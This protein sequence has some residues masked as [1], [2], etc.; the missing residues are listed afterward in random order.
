MA[1]SSTGPDAACL[2]SSPMHES[3]PF[4]SA[5]PTPAKSSSA[6]PESKESPLRSKKSAGEKRERKAPVYSSPLPPCKICGGK[7]SGL[8]YGVNTCEA[9]KLT[10]P[11]ICSKLRILCTET[12]FLGCHE[13]GFFRRAIKF[14]RKYRC[15]RQQRCDVVGGR[16]VRTSC[17]FCRLQKCLDMG[18][19][20]SAIKTG[21]YTHAKR[22]EN[23]MEVKRLELH[24]AVSGDPNTFLSTSGSCSS[25]GSGA[26][27]NDPSNSCHSGHSCDQDSD[28]CFSSGLTNVAC[29]QDREHQFPGHIPGTSGGSGDP[30]CAEDDSRSNV[31]AN[32]DGT[33][34]CNDVS[35]NITL[36]TYVK[37][38]ENRI[39]CKNS[40]CTD[41][42]YKR[43]NDRSFVA[44][45]EW[46]GK[47]T[48]SLWANPCN[49]AS[50]LVSL[51]DNYAI[52]N[53]REDDEEVKRHH[54][55]VQRKGV[56]Y[57][58]S[59]FPNYHALQEPHNQGCELR[60]PKHQRE[61]QLCHYHTGYGY[62]HQHNM[63]RH[64]N[65]YQSQLQQHVYYHQHDTICHYETQRYHHHHPHHYYHRQNEVVQD[66]DNQQ[67]ICALTQINLPENLSSNA[68]QACSERDSEMT[69]HEPRP[70]CHQSQCYP[71]AMIPTNDY[72]GYGG[73]IKT[74]PWDRDGEASKAVLDRDH[75]H[76]MVDSPEGVCIS[77]PS[78]PLSQLTERAHDSTEV[79]NTA[80]DHVNDGD[81]KLTSEIE[82]GE[83]KIPQNSNLDLNVMPPVIYLDDSYPVRRARE[84]CSLPSSACSV[85]SPSGMT[86]ALPVSPSLTLSPSLAS[87]PSPSML[88]SLMPIQPS[89][90]DSS[91]PNPTQV[92]VPILPTTRSSEAQT[93]SLPTADDLPNYWGRPS[94][95]GITS[96]STCHS[97]DESPMSAPINALKKPPLFYTKPAG[98]LQG[99]DPAAISTSVIEYIDAAYRKHTT[100]LMD[101]DPEFLYQWQLSYWREQTARNETFGLKTEFVNDDQYKEIFERTGLDIDNR[102]EHIS[103]IHRGALKYFKSFTLFALEIPGFATLQRED[104]IELLYG[105]FLEQWF[106][107]AFFGV[108]SDLSVII[109]PMGHPYTKSELGWVMNKQFADVCFEIAPSFKQL[110][111][112]S[113]IMAL[114]K[115]VVLLASDRC[116]LRDP[117]CVSR[118]QLRYLTC[119]KDYT[120]QVWPGDPGLLGHL[121]DATVRLRSLGHHSEA[122]RSFTTS[123]IRDEILEV[124]SGHQNPTGLGELGTEPVPQ[125]DG[126]EREH[127]GK[128]SWGEEGERSE[129]ENQEE[130]KITCRTGNVLRLKD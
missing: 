122:P 20:H 4:P 75:K 124:L 84:D 51:K 83:G 88:A 44:S 115:A 110:R 73:Q 42:I 129:E 76:F 30:M 127:A 47:D 101:Y 96:L 104:Q 79:T 49:G 45:E 105:S 100:T 80:G 7:A 8:H 18:M 9:C 59:T 50:E 85:S 72:P 106:L 11:S 55:D 23:I 29:V 90:E 1:A 91:N 65:D 69:Q 117:D 24:P 19:A 26:Y 94:Y 111:V 130:E 35:K 61:E 2:S 38:P 107:N 67:H 95:V 60:I 40:C 63:H 22:T 13:Q 39:A 87:T 66:C 52:R 46:P 56:Y 37:I 97:L 112:N 119:L 12:A 92:Q 102:K 27:S 126:L 57:E 123:Y 113:T 36:P 109:M 116:S 103:I 16:S 15:F 34:V 68:I 33:M 125:C 82:Q 74:E 54:L 17:P 28:S 31:S 25:F 32:K 71:G 78:P 5:P 108:N 53:V 6:K 89:N 3:S 14:Q 128:K 21:R 43:H 99:S 58:Q 10:K 86:L 64:H 41:S 70:P 120:R 48:K 98:S 62:H 81:D 93:V 118:L 121:V 114:W 77:I